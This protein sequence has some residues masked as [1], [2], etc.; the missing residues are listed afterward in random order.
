MRCLTLIAVAALAAA[1]VSAQKFD[2]RWVF[3]M[4]SLRDESMWPGASNAVATAA[5]NGMNGVLW[6]GGIEDKADEERTEGK[7]CKAH[8][9]PLYHKGISCCTPSFKGV[10]ESGPL[11]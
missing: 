11:V 6:S 7:D 9:L 2:E 1:D 10:V 4:G 5:A 8:F 3:V